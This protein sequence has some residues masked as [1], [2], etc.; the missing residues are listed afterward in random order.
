MRGSIWIVIGALFVTACGQRVAVPTDDG[1]VV[2]L[3]FLDEARFDAAWRPWADEDRGQRAGGASALH[4]PGAVLINAEEGAFGEPPDAIDDDVAEAWEDITPATVLLPPALPLRRAGGGPSALRVQI[5]LDLIRFS[6]G[7][8]DGKWGKNTEKAVYWFQHA[9]GLEASGEV[10]EETYRRLASLTG[11]RELLTQYELTAADLKGPFTR[12]PDDMYAKAKLGCLCY[13]SPMELLSERFHVMPD[14]LRQLNPDVDFDALAEGARIWVP[15]VHLAG[16]T[17]KD[18]ARIV[19]SKKG[20]YT[21]ALD[22]DGR[23]LYHFP[24]TLGSTYDPSPDGNFRVTSVVFDPHFH[25]Q[26]KLFSRVSNAKPE[27]VLPPGPNGPV[28]V[29]WI[30][31]S[32]RHVGIH[33]TPE[34]QTIGYTSSGG[35]VRLTN[36]DAEFLGKRLKRGVAVSFR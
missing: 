26:P 11:E 3:A 13:E 22:E 36:W 9:Q 34:P 30:G 5:R 8:L 20:F 32:K 19:I 23:I 31:L 21:H 6:P 24:S 35:C 17:V 18:V 12:V 29:V 10:D 25:Y 15:N 33:G 4:V 28:G 2:S 7:I 14:V 1:E 16:E 27:A